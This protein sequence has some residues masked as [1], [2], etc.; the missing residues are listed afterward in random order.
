VQLRLFFA[1][2]SDTLQTIMEVTLSFISGNDIRTNTSFSLNE[3]FDL[4]DERFGSIRTGSKCVVCGKSETGGCY[5]H[6]GRLYLGTNIFH[7]IFLDEISK[8]LNGICHQC[9]HEVDKEK[10][11]NKRGGKCSKCKE[12]VYI[13]YFI[14][15]SQPYVAKRRNAATT[16]LDP[17]QAKAILSHHKHRASSFIIDC[18]AVPP[19]GIRPP[20]DVE[21]PS[22]LS[23]LYERLV[24]LVK[25]PTKTD[26]YQRNVSTLY[27][28]IVGYL[29]KDGVIAAISGKFGIFRNLM[30][31]KRLNRSIRLVIAGDP[32]LDLDEILVPRSITERVR[33][34]ERVWNGNISKM[35]EYARNGQLWYDSEEVQVEQDEIIVGQVYDRVLHDGDWVTLNRQPSLSKTSLL[36]MRIKVGVTENNIF[37]FNPCIATAFNADFDGDEMNIY[38]GYGPE[39]VAEL[40]ELCHVNH[41]IYDPLTKKVFIQPIQDVVSAVYM[42]TKEKKQ[43]AKDLFDDCA[44]LTTRTL[45]DCNTYALF[46]TVLPIGMNFSGGVVVE[47]GMLVQG[48]ITKK[49]LNRLTIA[50][51]EQYGTDTC[52]TF[53]KQVQL[54]ALRWMRDKGF[55]IKL[56]DCV[57]DEDDLKEYAERSSAVETQHNISSLQSWVV[58]K[59]LSKY[60][61]PT[62]DN[63]LAVMLHSGAKGKDIGPSQMAVSIG[64]QYTHGGMVRTRVKNNSPHD[65]G[66]VSSGYVKGLSAKEYFSQ[67]SASLGGI[68]DIGVGVSAIGYTNRRVTKLM[69]GVEM[70]YNGGISTDG[71]IIRF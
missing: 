60:I 64:Q 38:T 52:A 7:S 46:S 12:T 21:W 6:H 63:P 18:V 42:M 54:V 40:Q 25:S 69:A 45:R 9:G 30:L 48:I 3:R 13:D 50:I 44:M 53:I 43:V 67:A 34:P 4:Y 37:A 57:W 22:D 71:Q 33:V 2:P 23:R 14:P 1:L 24:D 61:P 8:A 66:F 62:S 58:N 17:S 36:A 59:S 70:G 26:A 20:E 47:N 29:K 27:N 51:S 11:S 10:V 19:T 28:S 35:K 41:N 56:Q 16:T 15:P 31:G 68:I 49:V 5:G 32:H 65:T 39:A 55:T